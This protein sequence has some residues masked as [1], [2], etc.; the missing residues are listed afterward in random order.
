MKVLIIHERDLKPAADGGIDAQSSVCGS[1]GGGLA[2]YLATLVSALRDRGDTVR[3]LGFDPDSV[4]EE[5]LADGFYRVRCFRFKKRQETIDSFRRL[6]EQENPDVVHLQGLFYEMHPEMMEWLVEHYPTVW[7]MH[8]VRP[9]CFRG[10]RLDV[11]GEHCTRAVGKACVARGCYLPGERDGV[12]QDLLRVLL[13]GRYMRAYR[14]LACVT[15]VS[16][17][18][19]SALVDNGFDPARI[20]VTPLFSRMLE[21]APLDCIEQNQ[22]PR[23]LYVGRLDE[24]K[25]VE[26]FI[27]AMS[28]LRDERWEAVVVGVGPRL[29]AARE[30]AEKLGISDRVDF[31]GSKSGAELAEEYRR[32]TV[33]V[34]SSIL[35]EGGPLVGLEAMGFGKPVVAFRIGGVTQYLRH[36]HNGLLAAHRDVGELSN[37]IRR[38]IADPQLTQRLGINALQTARSEFTLEKH[39]DRVRAIYREVKSGA[40]SAQSDLRLLMVTPTDFAEMW[41]NVEHG[42]VRYYR[43]QNVPLTVVH[44]HLNRSSKLRNLLRDTFT[45]RTRRYEKDATQFVAVDPFFNYCS[46][47]R[48]QSD[49]Q[50]QA[51][52]GR[53]SWKHLL[54]RALAPLAILR[55]VFFTPC[56]TFAAMCRTS[57]HFDACLGIGPWGSLVGLI[58]RKLGRVKVLVYE[59]RDFDPGLMPDRLRQWYTGAV[60]RFVQRRADVVISVG[61]RLATLRRRESGV[62]PVV[63]SNG[64]DWTN[65]A[66]ARSGSGFGESMIYVGNLS[67]WSGI[68]QN[69]RAMPILLR[70]I[71]GAKLIIVG[72]GL[73]E[74]ERFLRQL[75]SDLGVAHAV[76]VLGSQPH[77]RLGDLMKHAS[78]GLANSEP[79]A[80]RQYACP[81]KVIEYMASGL[82]VIATEGT[83]A[84]DMLR[85]YSCGIV[86]PYQPE[87]IAAA[88]QRMLSD[89]ASYEAF[90]AAALRESEML[91]W[92]QLLSRERK[93]IENRLSLWRERQTPETT[94]SPAEISLTMKEANL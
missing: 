59:D 44:L 32:C 76:E 82:P 46:G 40:A 42:R 92:R 27:D 24:G 86:T 54:I 84:A 2:T 37:C 5:T 15:V 83:E 25:G 71:P 94:E 16:E 56:M 4:G 41:N 81:L 10:S 60:E 14:K 75:I 78:V 36:E 57:G 66:A 74:Y 28:R 90:R 29:S 61:H 6:V 45:F 80:Y 64:I 12:P 26:E 3:L 91:D 43:E 53:K 52:R 65:F 77:E 39:V 20:Q 17:Y 72:S 93:L 67:S 21:S 62:D 58:L 73:P 85:H 34:L 87:Q 68:E 38:L 51:D 88:M 7:T 8:D 18:L 33:F 70:S 30:L 50:V 19:R 79:V 31:L 69:I 48:V 89:R 11:R 22:T 1:R 63:I 23:I 9:L 13:H 47:M 55:D 49:A 35:P